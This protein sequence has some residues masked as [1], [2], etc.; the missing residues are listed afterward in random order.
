VPPDDHSA[1]EVE[2]T[3][4]RT[5][6]RIPAADM[7]EAFSRMSHTRQPDPDAERA[8]VDN[9]LEMIRSHPTLS[10]AEKEAA[11]REVLEQ[12]HRRPPET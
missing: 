10:A 5:G 7:R 11:V 9:K 1:D 3:D 4:P 12:L 2:L 8:F 6:E